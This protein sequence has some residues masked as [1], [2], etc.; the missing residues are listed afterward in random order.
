MSLPSGRCAYSRSRSQITVHKSTRPD[1]LRR[2]SHMLAACTSGSRTPGS[3]AWSIAA[4]GGCHRPARA[5]LH[6]HGG[7]SPLAAAAARM[8]HTAQQLETAPVIVVGGGAAGLTAAYFAAQA[9]AKVCEGRPCPLV[10]RLH[11]CHQ[12]LQRCWMH[13]GAGAGEDAGGGEEG[14]DEWRHPLVG[15]VRGLAA[16]VGNL[17]SM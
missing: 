7:W 12:P 9:G 10:R 11:T 6:K 17:A 5:P 1:V 14:V 13:A 3:F 15:V 4:L 2:S 16:G 8:Q